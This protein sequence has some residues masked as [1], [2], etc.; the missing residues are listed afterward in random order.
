MGIDKKMLVC[1]EFAAESAGPSTN[2]HSAHGK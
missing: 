2:M 1:S